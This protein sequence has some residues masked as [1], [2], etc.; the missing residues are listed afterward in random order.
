LLLL[1]L[2]ILLLRGWHL[3]LLWR[4][5]LGHCWLV[6][7]WPS[8]MRLLETRICLRLRPRSCILLD[9]SRSILLLLHLSRLRSGSLLLSR[10]S[11]SSCLLRTSC[12]LRLSC[13]PWVLSPISLRKLNSNL[14]YLEARLGFGE[15]IVKIW[16]RIINSV[17]Q[18]R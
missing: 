13:L 4:S 14:F 6:T 11:W 12:L 7:C 17:F 1:L 8:Y 18:V 5:T 2:S 15:H 10:W 3:G 9:W 16:S